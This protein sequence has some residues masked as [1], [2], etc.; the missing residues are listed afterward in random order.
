MIGI[1]RKNVFIFFWIV[2]SID[3]ISQI[4]DHH[5][6][7]G[8]CKCLLMPTLIASVIFYAS[9]SFFRSIILTGLCFSF[10]GDVLL[11]FESKSQP[12]FFIAGLICFLLTH[13]FYCI[14]F[15]KSNVT[16]ASLLKEKP[17]LII[18][19]AAYT[20]LL[21]YLLFPTLGALKI[22]VTLYAIILSLMFICSLYVYTAASAN[23]GFLFVTGALFFVLS[24][25]LLAF[26]KFYKPLPYAGPI[27][28][29]TYCMAQYLLVKGFI[30]KYQKVRA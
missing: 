29:F 27:I 17:W 28:M 14:L 4:I 5:L 23:V 2:V 7:H 13:T 25:S 16:G 1:L 12:L 15:L 24:D 30:K 26:N 6:L 9:P 18:I 11:L 22:P 21:L 20:F 10:A 3:I 8:I 19:V